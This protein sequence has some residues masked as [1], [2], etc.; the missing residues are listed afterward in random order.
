MDV[1]SSPLHH[2][3][4]G[5][6]GLSAPSG[7]L[8]K[9]SSLL[10]RKRSDSRPRGRVPSRFA[11]LRIHS[12][13]TQHSARCARFVLGYDCPAPPGLQKQIPRSPRRPRDDKSRSRA[14]NAGLKPDSSPTRV[15]HAKACCF[16]PENI[17]V[18]APLRPFKASLELRLQPLISVIQR[19]GQHP[20]FTHDGH[21]IGIGDPAR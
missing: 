8:R 2:D 11:G 3:R 10:F 4:R 20:G 16:H 14:H 17:A 9:H 21:E 18:T 19:F 7:C 5:L 12:Q 6:V 13:L 15:H 1:I